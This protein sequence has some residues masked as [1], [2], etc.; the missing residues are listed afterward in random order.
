MKRRTFMK[1]TAV[2]GAMAAVVQA[3][4]SNTLLNH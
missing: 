3:A 1:S 4:E 2:V